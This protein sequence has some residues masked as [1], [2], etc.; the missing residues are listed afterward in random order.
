[1]YSYEENANFKGLYLDFYQMNF[2][3]CFKW[4]IHPLLLNLLIYIKAIIVICLC[5]NT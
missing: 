4:Q 1:M 5:D 3:F 2:F